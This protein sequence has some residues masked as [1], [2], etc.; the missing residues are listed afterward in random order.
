[1]PLAEKCPECG[2]MLYKKKSRPGALICKNK[3][4]GYVKEDAIPE[5]KFGFIPTDNEPLPEAPMSPLDMP[6]PP[7][8]DDIPF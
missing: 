6:P 3:D 8:D 2:E 5:E 1:M 4:C 7:G